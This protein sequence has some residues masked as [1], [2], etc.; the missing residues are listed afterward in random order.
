MQGRDTDAASAADLVTRL[1]AADLYT[2]LAMSCA[3]RE[4]TDEMT[5][6]FTDPGAC[7]LCRA[8]LCWQ[9]ITTRP[10]GIADVAH[11]MPKH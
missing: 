11:G 1:D 8:G 7:D 4:W 3:H 2:R 10:D 9:R 5:Q 6:D